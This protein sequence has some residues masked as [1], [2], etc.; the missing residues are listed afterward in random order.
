MAFLA[1][2][3]SAEARQAL[4]E[5]E[6]APEQVRVLGREAYLHLPNGVGRSVLAPLLERRLG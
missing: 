1:T 5:I 2:T 6:A 3:P 4:E